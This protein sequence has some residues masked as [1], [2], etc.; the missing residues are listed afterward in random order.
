M[1]KHMS[2]ERRFIKAKSHIIDSL[3]NKQPRPM[4]GFPDLT[5]T[6]H[7]LYFIQSSLVWDWLTFLLSY[8][9][10][11]LVIL[12]NESYLLKLGLESGILGLFLLDAFTDFYCRSFDKFKIKNRYPNFY[13]FK[14][15]L[16]LLMVVDLI[17]FASMPCYNNRPV[18]PFRILR[19]CKYRDM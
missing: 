13:Y 8:F 10:M 1:I 2:L 18:R 4:S 7:V 9:F 11:F 15:C 3:K 17:I 12:D 16:L 19:A 5:T 14:L 6:Y